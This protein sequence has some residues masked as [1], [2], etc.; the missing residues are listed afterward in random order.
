MFIHHIDFVSVFCFCANLQSALGFGLWFFVLSLCVF[1]PYLSTMPR[2]TRAHRTTSTSSESPPRVE[3]FKNDK[4]RKAYD[5]LNCKCKIWSERAVIL[6]QLD[7][8]I[9]A[10]FESRGWLPLL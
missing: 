3:L 9:R 8:A 5:S 2:K 10:K 4:C 1:D 7:P 6:D